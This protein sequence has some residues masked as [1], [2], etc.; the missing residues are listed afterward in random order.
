LG[1]LGLRGKIEGN[2]LRANL[3]PKSD[4]IAAIQNG[5]LVLTRNTDS[6]TGRLSAAT[7]NALILRHADLVVKKAAP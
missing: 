1:E 6:L 2:E 4:D 3:V 5:Y 7:G